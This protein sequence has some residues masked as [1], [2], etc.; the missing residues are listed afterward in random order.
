MRK[1]INQT[2]FFTGLI[3]LLFSGDLIFAETKYAEIIPNPEIDI[4]STLD[5]DR[6]FIGDRVKLDITLRKARGYDVVFPEVPKELGDFT[7]VESRPIRGGYEYLL[8]VY[9]TG[10]HIIPPIQIRYKKSNTEDWVI[11]ESPKVSVEVL[12]VLTGE[13]KDI[14]DLK[15]LVFLKSTVSR[16]F[17]AVVL[18]FFILGVIWI[19]WYGKK[20]KIFIRRKKKIKTPHDIA[21]KQLEA[22]RRK[23]LPQ[24]GL[25]KMYYTE[26]SDIIRRYIENRFLLRA[27]EMTTEEF[28]AIVK[29]SSEL[30]QE[31]KELLKVFLS[32]CDMVKFAKYGPTQLE[33]VDS[34]TAAE[35][36]IAQTSIIKKEEDQA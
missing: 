26:L 10:V 15:A 25:I 20:S 7:F 22:L 34:F 14:R 36:F 19:I 12:S 18:V 5:K 32:Q 23:E 30:A 24:K 8:S 1:L 3:L 2:V 35:N 16:I 9:E 28:M 17:F 4:T 29:Q 33:M 13:E 27:P 31:H 11:A 21:Y 6:V